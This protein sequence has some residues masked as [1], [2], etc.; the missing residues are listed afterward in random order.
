MSTGAGKVACVTGASGYIASWLVKFLLQRGY[1]VKA[2]VRDPNN[3]KKVDH[4]VNLDGAKERLQLFKADLLDEGSFDSAVQG[5]HAVFHTA[6]PFFFGAKDPQAELLDPAVKGTLNVLKSCLKSATLKRV[7]V[8]SSVAAVACNDRPRAPDEVLDETWFSDAEFCRRNEGWYDLSKTLAE[9]I[10]WKFAKENNIDLVTINP[11]L[12]SGPLLQPELNT[13]AAAVLNFINGS[14]T[15]KNITLGWIDVRD[16]ANAHILAYENASANGRYI[17][18]E[19]VIHHSQA[20]QILRDIYPT[21]PLPDKCVDDKPYPPAYQF[22]KERAKSLGLEFTPLEVSL[23][24]TVES[25][26]EK[27]FAKF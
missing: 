8:T 18:V 12:V 15:F 24:D 14:A 7:V 5:C 1:T 22:S 27:G 11:A 13:S 26:R 10:A 16:V 23:K 9:E 17:L 3:P 25:L 19:R 21:L 20:V 4:L 2:T 6:S